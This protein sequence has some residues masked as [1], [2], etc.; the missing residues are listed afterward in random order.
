MAEQEFDA[1]QRAREK[2]FS[3]RRVFLFQNLLDEKM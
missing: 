3:E 1:W 2:K